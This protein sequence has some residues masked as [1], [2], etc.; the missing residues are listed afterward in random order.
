MTTRTHKRPSPKKSSTSEASKKA[1]D[2]LFSNS[3]TKEKET[4]NKWSKIPGYPLIKRLRERQLELGNFP[5]ELFFENLQITQ[6][7]WNAF[8]NG[9]R[10]IATL[11]RH[12]GRLMWMA[13]F[14]N[15]APITVRVLAGSINVEEFAM[16]NSLEDRL[17]D[18]R[19]EINN[20]PAFAVFTHDPQTWDRLP[21]RTRLLIACLY[22]KNSNE[23][24]LDLLEQTADL[25]NEHDLPFDEF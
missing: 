22:Q 20:D 10:N 2:A 8:E 25:D 19:R 1:L 18:V 4:E 14:L 16:A 17:Q 23:V 6:T 7:S 21:L 11:T 5:D 15:V 13:S 9:S 12:E 24:F 3:P